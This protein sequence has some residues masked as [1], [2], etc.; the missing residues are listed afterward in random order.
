MNNGMKFE[1]RCL[2][3]NALI[4]STEARDLLTAIDMAIDANI[5]IEGC[6]VL[7][8]DLSCNKRRPVELTTEDLMDVVS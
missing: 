3:T 1:V 8:T 4:F 6:R 5:S 2:L 7:A